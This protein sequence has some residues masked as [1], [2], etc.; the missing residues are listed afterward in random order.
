M[1]ALI[2][3][4][5]CGAAAAQRDGGARLVA[6]LR[7]SL[8]DAAH[9]MQFD[10][11][12]T[13]DEGD[14]PG[15]PDDG[16]AIF[17]HRY[18]PS[19]S[20]RFTRRIAN[21]AFIAERVREV[22][23]RY[24]HILFVHVSMQFGFVEAPLDG[25]EAWT[26][27]MFLTPSYAASG[28]RVPA[29]YTDLERRA[30]GQ[31]GQILTPSHLERRQLLEAYGVSPTRVRV[32]PRGVDRA[33]LSPR[34]RSLE[35]PLRICS[36]GSVKRQKNTAGLVRLFGD[37]LA[38]HPGARLR[39]VGP[40]QDEPYAAEVRD[41]IA[42]LGLSQS[43]ELTGYVPAGD[44][45]SALADA[46]IHLSA[47]SCETFG[48][49]IFETLAIGLPNV[50]CAHRNA[51]ADYLEHAPYARFYRDADAALQAID[52]IAGD[53]DRLSAMAMEVGELFDDDLLGRRL[54]AELAGAEP[55]AVCDFDG[56]LYHK[57]DPDRTRRSVEAFH[58][59]PARAVCSARSV[60]DLLA[61]MEAIGV[62]ADFV[63]GW[64]GAV[65]ADREGRTLWRNGFSPAEADAL[66]ARLP[67]GAARIVDGGTALQFTLPGEALPGLDGL[68]LET[69]QGVTFV[70]RW[71]S[72]KL[73]AVHRLLRHLDWRGSVRAFGDGRYDEELL[74]FFDGVRIRPAGHPLG[75]HRQAAEVLYERAAR[76]P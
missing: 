53:L 5:K 65:A 38:R 20:D 44:L 9:V 56:T 72:S 68:R 36:V 71:E 41:E 34:A 61:A 43:V 73:R 24:T 67:A 21:G 75:L 14:D 60:P 31:T 52:A 70:G 37:V 8:G 15:A 47:S 22:A 1:R 57:A 62:T 32:L 26:F 29:A 69:Y 18:P 13:G 33:L 3:T 28:E 6:T 76:A 7:R 12:D 54:A 48:R 39:I 63:L 42:R 55:F 40:V 64:S 58:R 50:A 46:H 27:P 23:A 59:Y 16:G 35:G 11:G 25:P 51:A 4:E 49:A 2:V 10:Q 19:G 30:L 74:T 17:R 45:S 66:A